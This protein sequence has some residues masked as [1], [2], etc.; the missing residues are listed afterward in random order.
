MIKVLNKA[1]DILEY[2]SIQG[3][4]PVGMS[5]IAQAIGEPSTTTANILRTMVERGYLEKDSNRCYSLGY[6]A[7]SVTHSSAYC[8]WLVNAASDAFH[9][10]AEKL[11]ETIVL[12]VL[13][14]SRKYNLM[15][16]QGEGAVVVSRKEM[17]GTDLFYTATGLLLTA[18]ADE[19]ERALILQ[20][21][22]LPENLQQPGKLMDA[23][24][25][26]VQNR[27]S[28]VDWKPGIAQFAVPIYD[29]EKFV[30][31]LGMYMPAYQFKPTKL[32]G[33][34]AD[35]YHAAGIIGTRIQTLSKTHLTQS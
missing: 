6:M 15:Q 26:I 31:A 17:E 12:V 25:E 7:Y 5:Q 32:K 29:G 28:Y 14:N 19:R 30:A 13:R 24:D 10:L 11:Q 22:A 20:A 8:G 21:N 33:I 23:L 2:L 27:Y 3:E 4:K 35:L 18:F 16:M 9:A 34:L 1:F